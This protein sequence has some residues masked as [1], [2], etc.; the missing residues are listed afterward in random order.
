MWIGSL[1]NLVEVFNRYNCSGSHVSTLHYASQHTHTHILTSPPSLP[2]SF[3]TPPLP[4]HTDKVLAI[5]MIV[6]SVLIVL[7]V[8]GPVALITYIVLKKL[9]HD[10]KK[11]QLLHT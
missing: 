1:S 4:L 11:G 10:S 2:T 6:A 9:G 7:P 5:G 3:P 8:A